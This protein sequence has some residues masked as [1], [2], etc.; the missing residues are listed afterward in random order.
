MHE[1]LAKELADLSGMSPE[2]SQF[3]YRDW[4]MRKHVVAGLTKD[5][6]MGGYN[7]VDPAKIAKLK[8]NTEPRIAARKQA[9]TAKSLSSLMA[10]G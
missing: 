5:K 10:L 9:K 8:S 1:T 4:L 3:R 6:L 2:Q 7:G